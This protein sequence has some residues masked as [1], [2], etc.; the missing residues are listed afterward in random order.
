MTEIPDETVGEPFAVLLPG[1]GRQPYCDFVSVV[2]VVTGA[3]TVVCCVVV[4]SLWLAL[5]EA[6]PVKLATDTRAAAMTQDRM[7]FFIMI[8]VVWLICFPAHDCTTSQS[9]AIRCNPTLHSITLPGAS[10]GLAGGVAC[11]T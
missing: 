3:G 2:V 1:C 4:V 10:L 9:G 6:Q 7:I 8:L 11:A 5:S